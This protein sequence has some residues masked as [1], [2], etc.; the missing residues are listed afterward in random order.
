[1]TCLHD[2]EGVHLDT[3]I[4]IYHETMRRVGAAPMYFFPR[5][6]FDKLFH[7]LG[8][9]FHLAFCLSE[10]KIVC[11]GI[12]IECGDVLQYHLGGTRNGA[13][14]FAPMKLLLD[15]V[16]IWASG[17]NLKVFHLGGGATAQADDPLLHFKL[18]FSSR[19]HDF[20][21]WRWVL[22]SSAHEQLCQERLQWLEANGISEVNPG[23]FPQYR[24]PVTQPA[25]LVSHLSTMSRVTTAQ[26]LHP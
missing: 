7:T 14:E 20:A 24:M 1:V 5:E 13:L 18:G 12:F 16:R 23:F 2:P 6:Y 15:E 26:E 19:V 4:E 8:D 9:R 3:F 22:N 17:R 21:V 11:G 25:S 10:G